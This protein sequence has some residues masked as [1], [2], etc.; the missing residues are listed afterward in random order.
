MTPPQLSKTSSI[1]KV[2]LLVEQVIWRLK[3]FIILF[4]EIPASLLEHINGMLLVCAAICNFKEPL[5]FD[6]LSKTVFS[7]T[8]RKIKK[9][10]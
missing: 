3:I 7:E 1:A 5:Y 8:I 2:C 9:N 6:C 10:V 4:N